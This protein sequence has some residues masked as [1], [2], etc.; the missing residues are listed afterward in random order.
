MDQKLRNIERAILSGMVG[1]T[2]VRLLQE[3]EGRRKELTEMLARYESR[4]AAGKQSLDAELVRRVL[5]NLQT[6]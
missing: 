1:Q 5:K 3:Y 2:T 6:L 4:D